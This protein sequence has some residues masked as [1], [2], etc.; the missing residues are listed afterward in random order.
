MTR[1]HWQSTF[2]FAIASC[3]WASAAP[4]PPV[5]PVAAPAVSRPAAIAGA[6]VIPDRF[7]RRWDPVTVFFSHD[8]GP[9]AGGA[10]DHPERVVSVTPSH[11]GV[12]TWLDAR[13][14]QFKPAEPWPPLTRF[15][16]TVENGTFTLATLMEAPLRT[17]PADREEGLGTVEAITLTFREPLDA[18]ALARMVSIELKPLPGIGGG[19]GRF[20][21]RDDFDVKV[22]ERRSRSDEASY[23][24]SLKDPIPLGTRATVH[25][26]LSLEDDVA[27]S[28]ADVSFAT[29]EP[30]RA[31]SVGCGEGMVPITPDGTRYARDQA[32]RC[33][34]RERTVTVSFSAAPAALGPVVAR[35]LVRF[36]PAVADLDFA[37]S[38]KELTI[39]GKFLPETLYR[40]ALVP[41]RL[42]DGQGRPLEMRGPSELFLAFPRRDAFLRWGASQGVVER[43]G[44]Q[45]VPIEGRADERVD[46]RIVRVDPLDRS[47]WPFPNRPVVVDEG[48]RPPG[49]G[50]EPPPFADP[51]RAIGV[52]ELQAHIAALATPPV[53]KLVSLPLR[54]DADAASFGL[55]LA[56]HLA[57]LSGKGAAGTY[58]VGIR[59]LA[60]T[61]ERS[62][63][64][65]QVTDLSLTV[66]EEPRA[67]RFVVTS[68]SS[69]APV[70][71][72]TVRVEGSKSDAWVT[73]VEGVTDGDGA[74]LWQPPGL[75]GIDIRRIVVGKDGD[76][77]VLDPT[78]PSDAYA[79]NRWS[80]RHETWLQWTQG[81]LAYR[82]PQPES[83]CHIF[84][85]RP[86]YR[87][88]E[89]V[90]IKGYLR[91]RDRGAL[92]PVAMSGFVVVEGPG[93]LIWRLPVSLSELGTFSQTF[94]AEKLPTG[95]YHAHLEDGRGRRFGGVSFRM[96]AYRIPEFE[97]QLHGPDTAA[98]D[99]EFTVSLTATYY[100]GGRV[101][102]RPVRWRVT[103]FPFTWQPGKREGFYFSTDA[104]FSSTVEF[105]STPR[106]EKQD[107]TDA[108]GGASIVLNPAVE[109]SAAPRSYVVE[110]TVTGADDQTVTATREIKALPPFV[111]GL[112]VPRFLQQATSIDPEVVVVGPGDQPV[113]GQQVTV[114]LLQRQW[115]SVLQASDFSQG[116]ARYLTDVVDEKVQETTVASGKEPVT[117]RLP[118]A[119]AGVYVVELEA[120]DRL[121]RSQ[122]VAVD[123]YVGGPGTMSWPKPTTR[124]FNVTPDRDA[125]DPGAT[126]NVVLQ[127]PFQTATALAVVEAP[128]GNEY[129]WIEVKGGSAS[130]SLAIL[131]TYVPRVPVHFVLMR[132][133]VPGSA[134]QPGS[135]AD[136]GK[137]AT[138]AATAWLKVNPVANRV[139]VKLEHPAKARPGETISMTI[140]LSDPAGKP[141]AGEVTLWLVDQAVLALGKEQ[142]LDPLPDFITPVVSHLLVRDTRNGT[143]GLLPFAELP[144]GEAAKRERLVIER[145]TVRKNFKTVPYY[146]AAIVVGPDGV[147]T[148]QIVLPDNL[149]NFAVR[150]KAVSGPDRFGYAASTIAVRLPVIVQPALP[151]FVRPGDTFTAAA[152]A[153]VVEGEGGPGAAELQVAGVTLKGEA[154]RELTLVPNQ[155]ERIDFAIDVPTPPYRDDGTLAYDTVTFRVGVERLS[156]Q[157]RDAFE[158]TLPVR[159]D[160]RRVTTRVLADLEPGKPV[161]I[162]PVAEPARPGTVR[163]SLLVSDQPGLVRMAA[164]LDFLLAYPYDCTEQ[165]I[166][167]SR[168]EVALKRFRTLLHETGDEQALD[169][170]VRETLDWLPGVIDGDGLA[171]YWP[172]SR[173]YVSLTAWV[174]QFLVEARDAGYQVDAKLLDTLT[175]SLER[176]LRSD[177]SRFIDGEAFA[178]RCW[179]LA[180]LAQ[181]GKFNPAYAAELARK[182]QFLDL[183]GIAEVLQSFVRS[184]DTSSATVKE[185]SAKLWDGVVVRLYQGREIYGGLQATATARNGLILPTETRTVAELTR[186]LARTDAANPRFAVLTG[187]LVTLGRGDGWGTT[188]A[189]AAALLALGE[190]LKPPFAGSTPH[191]VVVR[192]GETERTLTIGPDAPVA[193]FSSLAATPGEVT[194]QPGG[195]GKVVVR[196]ETSYVPAADGSQVAP[197]SSGFVVSRELLR[198]GKE[199]EPP[200]RIALAVPGATQSFAVG[201]VV[202]EHVQVVNQ[203]E[204]HYVAVVVPLAAGMEPLN[205]NLATAPPEAKPIGVITLAPTYLAFLDDQVGFYYD[206]LPGGTYDFYFRTRATTAGSFIQP[207]AQAEL[208]YDGAVRGHSAG[209]RIEVAR[210][211]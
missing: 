85:E 71:G 154:K 2:L 13:T 121:G 112:K 204:R 172:G 68:L 38:G 22:L 191:A 6:A 25:L 101:A 34:G 196:A 171:A 113:E 197:A 167:R 122:V 15:V 126:A 39:S 27:Q 48:E 46:L 147:A 78:R 26:R 59:R 92:K 138:M 201:D 146:N 156:D 16:W 193:A 64:R 186:A 206:T 143:F 207:P 90:Y 80:P 70:A 40:V 153:R 174:V 181:A 28:F 65:I 99:H 161:A 17:I 84:T 203:A 118:V 200:E 202:E 45:M 150:A 141:L 144:G 32:L 69:G 62:W 104:R 81:S 185:L 12:F 179:A 123:L 135:E 33:G 43:L 36:T 35:N 162:P 14:L 50:E 47:F 49:P 157:A 164:G 102:G 74:F 94:A 9:A 86:V 116:K 21:K 18:G 20:L 119:K 19:A 60:D 108:D 63:M 170:A 91:E 160:R 97:I 163:R 37:V 96:E 205:P 184:G 188:N 130:F 87:P 159:D 8:V 136:L 72:A 208:M 75:T 192:F 3:T 128:E 152:V 44:A 132:G 5:T 210:K 105:E 56:P 114:R 177:Y 137:P 83:L 98:L 10:E 79:D 11:P 211:P 1:S 139:D 145:T 52:G 117:V 106:L 149:T 95:T 67:V 24:L 42:E 4:P 107:T 194:L 142:R 140:R 165:R 168:A 58:L 187:A 111:L 134:P 88:E 158:V 23:V 173:G 76:T 89:T 195:S 82:G 148:V 7:L 176:A 189:T 51:S 127:S 109:A 41:T 100:A 175:R 180:A 55:D 133:R 30:F 183:E 120:A 57:F 151:R 166:S 169:R 54:K 110:A 190:L 198:Y 125:Y 178:E 209:A 77:L 155:P 73:A 131:P 124:V 129:R 66:A 103:Q 182:A 115:H 29:A 93:D 61:S 31:V 53:S 199:G